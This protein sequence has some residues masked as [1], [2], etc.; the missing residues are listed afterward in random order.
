MTKIDGF[1]Y[2]LLRLITWYFVFS[3]CLW[4]ATFFVKDQNIVM[5]FFH[6]FLMLITIFT[7]DTA[8]RAIKNSTKRKK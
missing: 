8:K 1:F 5:A 3:S 6:M 4:S 7:L 2:K